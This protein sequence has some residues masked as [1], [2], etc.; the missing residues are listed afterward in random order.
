LKEFFAR[1][2][3]RGGHPKYQVAYSVNADQT[4]LTITVNQMQ[5]GEAFL[6]PLPFQLTIDNKKV[7]YV[8][9]P[10]S[11]QAALTVPLKGKLTATEFD[12]NDTL[13][14]EVAK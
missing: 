11:K 10:T 3:Y 12:P 13:L 1:W 9:T 7:P 2:V 6:D 5:A 8:I 4:S 14:K